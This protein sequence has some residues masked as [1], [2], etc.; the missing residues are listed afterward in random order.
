MSKN[1]ILQ[2]V[3]SKLDA[4]QSFVGWN[5]TSQNVSKG[6]QRNLMPIK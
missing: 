4:R 2:L 1:Y 3:A 6:V 5:P